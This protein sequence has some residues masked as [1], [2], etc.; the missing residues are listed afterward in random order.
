[1]YRYTYMQ[2]LFEHPIAGKQM[3]AFALECAISNDLTD[4]ARELLKD[5]DITVNKCNIVAAIERK[6]HVM[7]ELLLKNI[8]YIPF[9]IFS[10]VINSCDLGVMRVFLADPRIDP[11]ACDN[12]AL[13]SAVKNDCNDIVSLLLTHPKIDPGYTN[14]KILD[15]AISNRAT[16]SV[17]VLLADGR[18]DPGAYENKAIMKAMNNQRYE[19]LELL[20]SDSRVDLGTSDNRLLKHACEIQNTHLTMILCIHPKVDPTVMHNTPIRI[21]TKKGYTSVVSKLLPRVNISDG[22]EIYAKLRCCIIDPIIKT[23]W[24]EHLSRGLWLISTMIHEHFPTDLHQFM[25]QV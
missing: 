4:I 14:Q 1:M 10:Y 23:L 13:R 12:L 8:Q 19:I 15:V 24:E 20:I 17:S 3:K 25:Y 21:A 6:H 2:A 11:S 16:R 9:G 18:I 7:V 22:I 5:P